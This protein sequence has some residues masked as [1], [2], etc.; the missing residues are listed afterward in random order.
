MIE[1]TR[2][3]FEDV[4]PSIE[5]AIRTADFIAI[6]SEFS[7]L[8]FH[9]DDKPS[10]FD[11][12]SDRYSKLRRSI[13]KF[14]LFQIGLST[15]CG[16]V[17]TNR[18]QTQTFQFYLFPRSFA[19]H[20][21][22]LSLQA[23]SIQFLRK[24][25][26]DFNKWLHDGISYLNC[27]D[28]KKVKDLVEV[29]VLNRDLDRQMDEKEIQSLCSHVA[30]WIPTSQPGDILTLPTDKNFADSLYV[31]HKDLRA[32][33]PQ[34]WTS[35]NAFDQVVVKRVTPTERRM[36]Q[37]RD[38]DGDDRY[39][40]QLLNEMLG[41]SRVFRLLLSAR[42]PI[43]GHNM[44]M[45]LMFMFD[46]FHMPLPEKYETFKLCIRE[47]FPV[48]FD[49]KHIHLC[50]KKKLELLGVVHA[51]SL[52]ELH[53]IL[54]SERVM[55]MSLLQPTILRQNEVSADG[56]EFHNAGYDSFVC[57]S[58]FQLHGHNAICLQQLSANY[59]HI[60]QLC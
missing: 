57:G 15:F 45:D 27:V 23:S 4:F 9:D 46:K 10:L 22:R 47:V 33:F 24:H 7:G 13:Q 35:T 31:F 59:E 55:N 50:I 3:N 36:S 20:D 56:D 39:Q 29:G 34:I 8:H 48:I 14:T 51:R 28:E 16:D 2:D 18:Y 58:E 60:S 26:F 30:A 40:Q 1:V 6:D 37:K 17:N 54:A 52:E 42:K 32:Q 5:Y 44:L 38:L 19:S 12:G 25:K 43:V 53:N 21:Q 41:F 49:T 11:S